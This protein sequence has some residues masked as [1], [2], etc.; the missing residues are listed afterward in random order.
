M[1]LNPAY[2]ESELTFDPALVGVWKQPE[3]N[4]T[5][6]VKKGG[7][8]SYTVVYTDMDGHQG[9]FIGHLAKVD[10]MLLL[11]LLPEDMAAPESAFYK[12]HIVPTHS[13]YLVRRTTPH[14]EVAA[15]DYK[16][17]E[18]YLTE[19]P[20]VLPHVTFDGRKIIT[21]STTELQNFVRRHATAFKVSV[22]MFREPVRE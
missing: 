15:I 2:T 5:W 7:D 14:L 21:A 6:E 11:D 17:L 20:T 18:E 19:N 10:E 12:L 3:S 16:W 4:A 13:V 1:S 9:R 8:K 22:T